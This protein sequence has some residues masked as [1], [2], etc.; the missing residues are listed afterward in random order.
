[1]SRG[2][3]QATP[4]VRRVPLLLMNEPMAE[5]RTP[6]HDDPKRLTSAGDS[7]AEASTSRPPALRRWAARVL[8]AIGVLCLLLWTA[9]WA[10]DRFTEA[11]EGRRLEAALEQ[12]AAEPQETPELAP[13]PEGEP[14]DERPP[15][16]EP[17]DLIG[18]IEVPRLSVS[19]IVLSGIESGTLR[20]AAGHVPRTAL[21]G[22]GGNIAVAGH[23]DR[24]FAGLRD[25]E[26]GDEITF[27]T[28]DGVH[29]Y[30]VTS[31]EVVDPSQVRVLDDRGYEELTLVTCYPFNYIGPAPNRFIVY[32][33]AVGEGE[34]AP[35]TVTAAA[36]R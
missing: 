10:E 15:P 28:P 14:V 6:E 2:T 33:K 17:G 24:H 1:M 7:A 22:H 13:P 31:T 9:A 11:I 23:R 36:D 32:A 4:P 20:R 34:T 5:T 26:I 18:R 35:E 30:R 25:V 19:A 8:I 27:S 16:P 12:A 21:P 3:R 29:R